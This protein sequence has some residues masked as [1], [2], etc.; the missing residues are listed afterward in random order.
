MNKSLRIIRAELLICL[1]SCL[2]LTG[3]CTAS[4]VSARK[5]LL[6]SLP[7]VSGI[8]ITQPVLV[9]TILPESE[10]AAVFT[11]APDHPTDWAD[12]GLPPG[13]LGTTYERPSHPSPAEE[14]PR[15]AMLAVRD[16]GAI[17]FL[18]VQRMGGFRMKS[19]GVW[20]FESERPLDHGVCQIVRV[21]ARRSAQEIEPYSTKFV[22]LIPGRIV[23][24]DF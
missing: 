11:A 20:L 16:G 10:N 7:S 6:M 23:Y 14:H 21:E 9:S 17:P 5:A 22:R 8:V 19:S 1:L 24:L 3:Q 12:A 15:T 18:T 2:C 13:T 4:E